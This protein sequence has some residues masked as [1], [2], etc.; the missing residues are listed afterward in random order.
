MSPWAPAQREDHSEQEL[1]TR[2]LHCPKT[3]EGTLAEG[4]VWH[5][6]HAKDVHGLVAKPRLKRRPRRPSWRAQKTLEDN[7]AN[8]RTQGAAQWVDEEEKE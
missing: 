2:C 8:A 4:R 1:V 5:A 6:E 7:I 3:F